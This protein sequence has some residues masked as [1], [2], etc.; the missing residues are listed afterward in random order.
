MPER[1]L[2]HVLGNVSQN[3][4][5]APKKCTGDYSGNFGNATSREG[6]LRSAPKKSGNPLGDPP[7]LPPDIFI[8]Y[9]KRKY[10]RKKAASQYKIRRPAR[11]IEWRV[12]HVTSNFSGFFF[13]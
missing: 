2:Q 1:I 13:R 3:L 11:L 8:G 10:P 12:S 6:I 9:M 7:P 5:T 4:R